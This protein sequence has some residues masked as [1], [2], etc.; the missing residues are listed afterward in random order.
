MDCY[1][2]IVNLPGK[3][4]A[5]VCVLAAADDVSAMTAMADRAL[6]WV[7]Y[8]TIFLY[9]GERFVGS[10]ADGNKGFPSAWPER[11]PVRATRAPGSQRSARFRQSA[12]SETVVRKAG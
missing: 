11:K 10:L 7:G 5:D 1:F 4:G 8:E 12:A 2:C 6:Y 3:M 9:Y